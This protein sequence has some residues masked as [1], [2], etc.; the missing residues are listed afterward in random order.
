MKKYCKIQTVFKR[1]PATKHKTLLEGDYS[2]PAFE[3]LANNEW[4]FTEKVDGTN[5]RVQFENGVVTFGGRTDNAQIPAFL[6]RRLMELFP[7]EKLTTVFPD[8]SVCLYGEGYGAKI[9]KC[10]SNY[11]PDGCG[12]ILFDVLCGNWWF[13]RRNVEDVASKLEIPI[14]PIIGTGTLSDAIE[15]TKRGFKSTIGDC[16][17][18]GIV[19]RPETE[20]FDRGGRRVIAKIKHRDFASCGTSCAGNQAEK[21][22]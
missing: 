4:V 2:I 7:A 5:I 18:E 12:F 20:L 21:R 17:A 15:M 22:Q 11:I 1:D 10:G 13:E 19:M 16:T 14:V 9:Q 3:Y 6:V 8:G